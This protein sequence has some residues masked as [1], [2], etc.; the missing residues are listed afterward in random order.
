MVYVIPF[1]G[2]W[3]MVNVTMGCPKAAVAEEHREG[4]QSHTGQGGVGKHLP[5]FQASLVAASEGTSI[6]GSWSCG[7]CRQ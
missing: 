2:L 4:V 7:S 5:S 3:Y 1:Y 6:G